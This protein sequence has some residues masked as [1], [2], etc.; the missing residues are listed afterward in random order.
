MPTRVALHA[1]IGRGGPTGLVFALALVVTVS[2][3]ALFYGF[4]V[5]VTDQAAGSAFSVTVLSAAYGGAVLSAGAAAIAVGRIA[6]RFGV[7][8]IIGAGALLGAL[9]LV[10]FASASA[11][12]QVLAIWWAVLGP[13]MAMTLYEPAYIAIQQWFEPAERARAIAILTLAAGLSGPIFIPGTGA[14]VEAIGWRNA[15]RALAVLFAGVGLSAALLG[16]PAGRGRAEIEEAGGDGRLGQHVR[17]F[18]RPRLLVFSVGA[19][20]AYG[21]LEANIIH[22]V[23]RFEE[24]GISVAVITYWAA[25]SG[26]LTLPGRFL[27]PMLGRRILGTRLLA[28]V[29]LVMALATGF[30]VPGNETWQMATYF[31]LFGLV[32][33]AALPLRAI[34][35][36]QWHGV[37]GFASVLGIQTAM[38][39]VSRAGAPPL[40]GGLRELGGGY[41]GPMATLTLL[42]VVAAVLV[43]VSEQLER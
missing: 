2:Y 8:A 36:S 32:F 14:L 17:A 3:G 16:V 38:I 20:L 7:R 4:S 30:M 23:A 40:I 24:G 37:A 27:L 43:V 29:L 6:D 13:V 42:F 33:G 26:L 25:L 22:R 12:W 35:M 28:G 41:A 31:C 34:V 1:V 21:A 9:G 15:A 5:L 18:G 11:S 39:S 10:A 19:F